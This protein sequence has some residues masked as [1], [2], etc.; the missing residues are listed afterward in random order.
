MTFDIWFFVIYTS[1]ALWCIPE[2]YHLVRYPE[3]ETKALPITSFKE[4]CM[5]LSLFGSIPTMIV[6]YMMRP[7]TSFR[8]FFMEKR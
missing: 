8:K 5:F 4:T 2:V 3:P 7:D 6:A 1:M